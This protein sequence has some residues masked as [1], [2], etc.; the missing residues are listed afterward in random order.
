VENRTGCNIKT[1]EIS[2]NQV[3]YS[4]VCNVVSEA[5]VIWNWIKGTHGLAMVP[6]FPFSAPPPLDKFLDE[7][8]VPFREA[9]GRINNAL[10]PQLERNSKSMVIFPP[11]Q[12]ERN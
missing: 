9:G 3:R 8:H 4:A 1:P 2:S 7:N 6:S 11:P 12:L 5:G 10:L